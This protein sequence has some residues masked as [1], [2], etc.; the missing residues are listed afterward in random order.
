MFRRPAT[1]ALSLTASIAIVACNPTP[2]PTATV[3]NVAVTA[4]IGAAATLNIGATAQ[5]AAKVTGT[6]NPAGTVTWTSSVPDVATVGNTT[7]LITAVKEG[8]TVV[9][10][11]STADKTKSGSVTITVKA[12]TTPTPTVTAVAVTLNPASATVGGTSQATASVTGTNSPAQ[13]VT[14]T[15]SNN[16]VAT[17]S[18][19]GLVTAVTPGTADIIATSTVDN[20]KKGQATF[21]VTA[22][23]TRPTVKIN[24]AP[25]TSPVVGYE[26]NSGAAYTAA[27]MTGWITEASAGTA[28]PVPLNMTA[29]VR[30]NGAPIVLAGAEPA[31]L[32]QINMQCGSATNGNNCASGTLTSGAFEYKMADGVYNVTVS[33]GDSSASTT[34]NNLNSSHTINVEGTNIIN[35][36]VPT[37]AK[38]FEKLTKQVTVS[39]GVMTIDA[40]GGKNTKINYIELVP[41]N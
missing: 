18:T 39:G 24:F 7:G 40:K 31:Q 34:P 28:A 27:S 37:S 4:P 35:N 38:I 41:V 23:G 3:T 16:A 33:V 25:A 13:T 9:T 2:T 5:A 30:P 1:I 22:V 21:T 19:T 11:T 6:N 17:V 14:W 36:F 12:A 32:T 8:T 10:A 26:T 15:S 29:N 20:T